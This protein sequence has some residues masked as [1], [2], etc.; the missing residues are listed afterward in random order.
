MRSATQYDDVTR[1]KN[2][3][4]CGF[5]TRL[6]VIPKRV[7]FKSSDKRQV[8]AVVYKPDKKWQA[9]FAVTVILNDG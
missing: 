3:E 6:F 9:G 7:R 2:N 8:P 1:K 4:V 5:N